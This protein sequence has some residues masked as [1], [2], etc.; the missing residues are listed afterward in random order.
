MVAHVMAKHGDL[1]HGLHLTTGTVGELVDRSAELSGAGELLL[2][3][4]QPSRH[5]EQLDVS[6][7][8]QQADRRGHRVES[9]LGG[10][11]AQYGVAQDEQ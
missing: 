7:H 9:R 8:A 11:V 10:R 5:A 4:A 6:Q 1:G 3:H 2:A